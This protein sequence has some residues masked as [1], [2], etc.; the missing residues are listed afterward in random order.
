[1]GIATVLWYAV[2][3]VQVIPLHVPF[4]P[5]HISSDPRQT[6]ITCTCPCSDNLIGSQSWMHLHPQMSMLMPAT[7]VH[8]TA[9]KWPMAIRSNTYHA[10]TVVQISRASCFLCHLACKWYSGIKRAFDQHYLR[11]IAPILGVS[12]WCVH[13]QAGCLMAIL[14]LVM[15]LSFQVQRPVTHFVYLALRWVYNILWLFCKITV[16]DYVLHDAMLKVNRPLIGIIKTSIRTS[17]QCE[18]TARDTYQW[19][20][21]S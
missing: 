20:P 1:M 3:H 5:I 12:Y 10:M 19:S 14:P 13:L 4:G 15:F 16:Q 8:I 2:H 11:H 7:A 18:W 21:L 6:F 9:L 17:V